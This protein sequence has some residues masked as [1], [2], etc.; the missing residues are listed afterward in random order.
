[1]PIIVPE[2]QIPNVDDPEL[3]RAGKISLNTK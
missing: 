1:M 3:K 2:P